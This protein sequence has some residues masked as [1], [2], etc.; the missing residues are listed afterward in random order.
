MLPIAG[1]HVEAG[2][3][4]GNLVPHGTLKDTAVD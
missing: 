1:M 2:I 3:L 4:T